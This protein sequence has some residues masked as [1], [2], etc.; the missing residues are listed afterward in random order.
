MYAKI[1]LLLWELQ[2]STWIFF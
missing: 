1:T 2:I